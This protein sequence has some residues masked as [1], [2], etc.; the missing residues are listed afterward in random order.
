MGEHKDGFR[1]V[2]RCRAAQRM[3]ALLVICLALHTASADAAGLRRHFELEAGD[4]SVMLNEFSRQS[5]LQVLFDFN[6]LRGMKTRAV[7]G[8]FDPSAALKS[9]LKGTN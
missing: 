3:C 6:I 4:A 2:T 5:D 7:S 1:L 9:M 8:D